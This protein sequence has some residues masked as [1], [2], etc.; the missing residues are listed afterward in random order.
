MDCSADS[1]EKSEKMG[2][3]TAQ[4]T[5]MLLPLSREK[6][7]E[8]WH[9]DATRHILDEN[10]KKVFEALKALIFAGDWESLFVKLME[11]QDFLIDSQDRTHQNF[12]L[13]HYAAQRKQVDCLRVLLEN[14]QASPNIQSESGSTAI[15]LLVSSGSVHFF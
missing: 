15:H 12:T 7:T 14:F 11:H 9:A 4:E 13:L 8:K 10:D 1:P 3:D 5:I 2:V 6:L